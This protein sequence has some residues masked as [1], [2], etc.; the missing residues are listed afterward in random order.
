MTITDTPDLL[1]LGRSRLHRNRANL[2]QT[3]QSVAALGEIG[4][5]TRL[6]LPPWHSSVSLDQRLHEMGI[7]SALDVRPLQWLH[8]RWP[9]A[10]LATLQGRQLRRARALYVRSEQLSLALA[11]HGIPHHLELHSLRALIQAQQ[12][13]RLIDYHR[14]GLIGQLLPISAA[15]AG[16]LIERGAEARRVHLCPSGVDLNAYAAIEP[17][18]RE[19]LV[20]PRIVYIGRISP[21]RGLGILSHLAH[22]GI[23]QV[24]LIGEA[25][26]PIEPGPHLRYLGSIPH[27][28]VPAQYA[29]SELVLLPYQ[30]ELEHADGISPMKLFEAMAAGR[31]I[32]ASDIPP[33]REIIRDGDNGLLV[34]PTDADAWLSAVQRLRHDPDLALRLGAQARLDAQTYG[35]PQRARRIAT[36]LQLISS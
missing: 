7:Y 21:D 8:R 16:H 11:A 9:L 32:L 28:E 19:R 36:A 4:V 20:Y 25:A 27:R 35:W 30:P 24:R 31:V 22:S 34:D 17:L 23:G 15:I 33:I 14:R 6:Y 1:Y 2:I 29:E 18:D 12:L 5:S 13:D 3:L 10:I 26:A